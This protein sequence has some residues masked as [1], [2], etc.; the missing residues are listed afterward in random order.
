MQEINNGEEMT[1]SAE[2]LKKQMNSGHICVNYWIHRK[3]REDM[4]KAYRKLCDKY[5]I[6]G[7]LR[8]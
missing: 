7:G 2:K 6:P 8:S 1:P 4:D 5:K 3:M